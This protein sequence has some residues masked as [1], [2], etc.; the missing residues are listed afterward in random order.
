MIT[1][2]GAG[3]RRVGRPQAVV[4]SPCGQMPRVVPVGS[5]AEGQLPFPADGDRHAVCRFLRIWWWGWLSGDVR[6]LPVGG[7]NA[8]PSGVLTFVA[9]NG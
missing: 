4:V 8:T 3:G 6:S 5:W 2:T 7:P 9:S 1:Y